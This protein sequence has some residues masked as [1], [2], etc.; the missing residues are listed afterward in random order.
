VFTSENAIQN[1]DRDEEAFSEQRR[2]S[3]I[4]GEQFHTRYYACLGR[5]HDAHTLLVQAKGRKKNVSSE[6]R[7]ETTDLDA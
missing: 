2:R 1:G 4:H 6:I 7:D 5:W 3:L